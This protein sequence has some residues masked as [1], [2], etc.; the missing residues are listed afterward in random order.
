VISHAV[1]NRQYID[2]K[3]DNRSKYT[4][5]CNRPDNDNTRIVCFQIG[6]TAL[7]VAAEAGHCSVIRSLLDVPEIE[8][9]GTD[10]VSLFRMFCLL[11]AQ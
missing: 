5:L 11:I 7:H 8:A 4:A 10:M 9:D 2:C 3:E 1:L 6:Q